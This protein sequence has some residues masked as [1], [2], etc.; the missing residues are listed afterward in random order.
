MSQISFVLGT[1]GIWTD[2]LTTLDPYPLNNDG[3]I[4]PATEV[5]AP[6]KNT[7]STVLFADNYWQDLGLG[8]FLGD[9]DG[10]PVSGAYIRQLED[11]SG[12]YWNVSA[13]EAP[14]H[15]NVHLW[16]HGTVDL[17]TPASDTGATITS[18]E[19]SNWWVGYEHEGTNAGF[20][21]SLIGGANRSSTNEPL[22]LGSPAIRSGYNQFWDFGA[23]TNANRTV[24]PANNGTWPNV[25]KFNVTGTNVVAAGGVIDT[26]LYYQYAGSSNLT[27]SIYYDDDFNP[28][29]TNSAPVME[30]QAAPTGARSVDY[31]SNLALTTSNLPPGIYA[32][33]AKISDGAHTR[34]LYTPELTQ[35]LPSQQQPI[36][37]TLKL[38]G[39]GIII[40][41]DG[42]SGQTIVLQSSPDL[43]NW[44]PV[45]TNTLTSS[46]WNY[47]NNTLPNPGEQFY[48]A[49]LAP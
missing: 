21:Y 26:T 2:H 41:V 48:R 19:R 27:L 9:P 43:R 23:G 34:Y 4:D 14:D 38:N 44:Q 11:L 30:W 25:I 36:L 37:G 8:V 12:G 45:A 3:N 5:D 39:A 33:Y 42:T 7:Y 16:Y 1:N 47:T 35:I 28:Y 20:D 46:Q 24:L 22:G 15:S 31:Y 49:M 6:A 13:V 18:T 17:D 10:E 40:R 29:N 32:I